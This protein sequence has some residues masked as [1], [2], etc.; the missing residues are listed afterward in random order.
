MN[1]WSAFKN[2]GKDEEPNFFQRI[3]SKIQRNKYN[4]EALSSKPLSKERIEFLN[5]KINDPNTSRSTVKELRKLL[6]LNQKN[7]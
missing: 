6:K 1:G 2:D 5:K 4:K 7:K 3:K